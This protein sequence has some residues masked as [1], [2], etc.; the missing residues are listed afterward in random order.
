MKKCLQ[1]SA[2][3][4]KVGDRV[5]KDAIARGDAQKPLIKNLRY[6]LLE[7]F[8]TRPSALWRS[9]RRE[10][11]L[12]SDLRTRRMLASSLTRGQSLKSPI[13]T[14]PVVASILVLL[15]GVATAGEDTAGISEQPDPVFKHG[16]EVS[17]PADCG[18]RPPQSTTR[19]QQNS[20]DYARNGGGYTRN[21]D[22]RDYLDIFGVVPP[23]TGQGAPTFAPFPGNGV[24]LLARWDLP[25]GAY[26]ALEFSV[27]QTLAAST[28]Y[29]VQ[30]VQTT[31]LPQNAVASM[32]VSEC[33]GDF[34]PDIPIACKAEW[35]GNDGGLFT[36]V[37]DDSPL[38][39]AQTCRVT[40]GKTYFFNI[41]GA[42]LA[43]P[44]TPTCTAASCSMGL[45]AKLIVP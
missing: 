5:G 41:V 8:G 14:L 42:H 12:Q 43:T 45:V 21:G 34:R 13:N 1:R 17:G 32:T 44:G 36:I 18:A 11:A 7:S 10:S 39:V 31:F 23:I 33:P 30:F 6:V 20:I 40:R 25:P 19:M 22:M 29:E 37:A 15:A 28:A 26:A 38:P 24:N 3:R 4:A 16:Y 35:D 2:W 27:P 9:P